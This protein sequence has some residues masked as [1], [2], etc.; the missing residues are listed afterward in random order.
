[1]SVPTGGL[2][3]STY[4]YWQHDDVAGPGAAHTWEAHQNDVYDQKCNT[5]TNKQLSL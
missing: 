4:K 3:V 2:K 1:V 5:T